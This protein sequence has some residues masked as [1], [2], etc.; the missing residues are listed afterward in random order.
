MI[1]KLKEEHRK[2]DELTALRTFVGVCA[3]VHALHCAAPVP[4]ALRDF[5]GK[6][7]LAIF[8][9]HDLFVYVSW[10]HVCARPHYTLFCSYSLATSFSRTT[11]HS[12]VCARVCV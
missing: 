6:K 7:F 4:L 1:G 3:G 12:V 2:T 8:D 9:V 11:S 5:K 10:D